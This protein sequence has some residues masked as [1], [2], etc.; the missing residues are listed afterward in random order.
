MHPFAQSQVQVSLTGQIQLN[1]ISKAPFIPVGRGRAVANAV[2]AIRWT[3]PGETTCTQT[4]ATASNGHTKFSVPG[5]RGTY[6]L[7]VTN[8][9]KSGFVLDS[10]GS[11]LTKSITKKIRL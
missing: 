7:T 3:L 6:T 5:P 11:V 9:T 8:M 4:A 2:V 1:R 10:P